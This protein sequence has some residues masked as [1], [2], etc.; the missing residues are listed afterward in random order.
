V[1]Y[2]NVEG[3]DQRRVIVPDTDALTI[4]KLFEEFATG[5]YSLKTLA[6]KC[7]VEGR[8]IRGRHLHKSTLHQILR[9]RIYTG[10]F[11]WDGATYTGRHEALVSR[12]T[13][14]RVQ[15]L[16][17]KRI[18]TKQHR[19]RH[20]FAF[21]GFIRCG[22]CGCQLLGELKKGR[23]V[24]YHCTGHRGKCVEPYTREEVMQDQLAASLR[25]LIVPREVLS[26]LNEALS[27]SDLTERAAREREI[28]RLEEQRRRLDSKLDAMYEDRLEGRITPEM[29]DRKAS[30]L[31][32][33]PAVLS[34][35]V[36]EIR[37]AAPAAVQEAID[38]M[39]LTSRAADLFALQPSTKSRVFS[40]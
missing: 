33:P 18:E 39:D 31:R 3:P 5:R 23:Y 27:Q 21:T 6:E 8:T 22:H 11:D 14:D 20:D 16:I 37:T 34:R 25:D 1:G 38:L 32:G 30:D 15:A 4:T 28:K 9:K 13:W 36:D 19:I 35:R 24:Y 10:D 17:D 2:R 7:R 26:W 12:E 40:D 29:Y